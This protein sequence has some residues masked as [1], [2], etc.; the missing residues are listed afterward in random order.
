MVRGSV[1]TEGTLEIAPSVQVVSTIT[2]SS[3]Q[4]LNLTKGGSAYAVI[5]ASSV[6]VGTD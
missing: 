5:K 1:T 4:S 3:A 6:M 2:S